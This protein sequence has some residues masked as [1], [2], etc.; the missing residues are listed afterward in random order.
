MAMI[1]PGFTT[2]SQSNPAIFAGK[3]Y[4]YRG[5]PAWEPGA[6]RYR[7][8]GQGELLPQNA[9]ATSAKQKRMAEYTRLRLEDV[10]KEQA[11]EQIGI[12]LSTMHYYERAFK[13]QHPE[14][15]HA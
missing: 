1:K 14:A 11:A 2:M 6:R 9:K 3:P 10:P 8:A 13:A 7:E 15:R 12:C 4:R 5:D